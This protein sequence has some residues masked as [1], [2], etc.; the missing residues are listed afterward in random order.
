MFCF[1]KATL[2]GAVTDALGL[3]EGQFKTLVPCLCP[4]VLSAILMA[5]VL[6]ATGPMAAVFTTE[7]IS[8]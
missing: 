1:N 6:P 4:F 7:A 5:D 8:Q 2:V 3:V